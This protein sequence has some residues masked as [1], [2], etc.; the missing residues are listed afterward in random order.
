MRYEGKNSH[1]RN[2]HTSYVFFST[3][4]SFM[5]NSHTCHYR[6]VAVSLRPKDC[7][8]GEIIYS[9]KTIEVVILQFK[10]HCRANHMPT[11]YCCNKFQQWHSWM[12]HGETSVLSC[13]VSW[14]CT[15][16]HNKCMKESDIRQSLVH[17]CYHLLRSVMSKPT[18]I[19]KC[20]RENCIR[21]AYTKG[22]EMSNGW[23]L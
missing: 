22:F 3:H 14:N 21:S 5:L 4:Q 2:T 1:A 13:H 9:L 7:E 6:C 17:N 18:L 16:I 10:H 20:A 15:A 8:N 11:I 12:K 19:T 23:K